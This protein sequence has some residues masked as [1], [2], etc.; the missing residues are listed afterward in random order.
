MES[1]LLKH[2]NKEEKDILPFM[3]QYQPSKSVYFRR[4]LNEEM[5]LLVFI[6]NQPFLR[7]IFKEPPHHFLQE[8]K[9]P[10]GHARQS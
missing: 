4:S 5:E 8:R 6:Q 3:T 7:Q 1:T 10:K 2:N 9:I